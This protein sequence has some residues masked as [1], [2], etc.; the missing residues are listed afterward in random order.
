[1]PFKLAQGM[2]CR[3]VLNNK[4]LTMRKKNVPSQHL[5]GQAEKTMDR[6][7]DFGVYI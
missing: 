6:I 7:D 2:L 4:L 5:P 3:M 1:M